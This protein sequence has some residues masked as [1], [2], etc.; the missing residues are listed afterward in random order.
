MVNVGLCVQIGLYCTIGNDCCCNSFVISPFNGENFTS[1]NSY[2]IWQS[3]IKKIPNSEI[4]A[5][6]TYP[7]IE[8]S[9]HFAKQIFSILQ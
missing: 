2:F 8:N 5:T 4:I 6:Q 3:I 7:D 9:E 1:S